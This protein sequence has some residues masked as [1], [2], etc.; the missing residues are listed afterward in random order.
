MNLE[1]TIKALQ[2][3]QIELQ[4]K[5]QEN[6]SIANIEPEGLNG[7]S[8][9]VRPTGERLYTKSVKLKKSEVEN[10]MPSNII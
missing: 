2:K 7:I 8:V 6:A 5:G 3:L 1:L 4:E 9:E 10:W